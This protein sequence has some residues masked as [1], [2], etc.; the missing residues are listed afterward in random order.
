MFN[1]FLNLGICAFDVEYGD[2]KHLIGKGMP[3]MKMGESAMLPVL[4]LGT[5]LGTKLQLLLEL[6]ILPLPALKTGVF[7][8]F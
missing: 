2:E 7:Y 4:N 3:Y 8:N 1:S 5:A 6:D